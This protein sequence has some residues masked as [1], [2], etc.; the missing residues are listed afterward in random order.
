MKK[1]YK[2]GVLI[3]GLILISGSFLIFKSNKQEIK[4]GQV[5]QLQTEDAIPLMTLTDTGKMGIGIT[6]P[7][8]TLSVL[9]DIDFIGNATTSLSMV[10]KSLNAGSC[11]VKSDTNGLL[12]C[13]TDQTAAGGGAGS[14][15]SWETIWGTTL[16]P[17]SS[18]NGIFVTAS[19]TI[20]T[21]RTNA[22]T[23]PTGGTLTL[24]NDII[25]DAMVSNTLTCSDTVCSDCLNATEIEDIYLF[26]TG[27]SSSGNYFL[28]GEF[29]VNNASSTITNL[30]AKDT[31][32][33]AGLVDCDTAATSKLLWDTTNKVFSC[34]TDQTGAAGN[35]P[36]ITMDALDTGEQHDVTASTALTEITA[37]SQTLAAGTYTFK[38]SVIYRSNQLTNGIRLAVNYSGTNGAFVWWW[39][40]AD[41]SAIASTAVPDQDDVDAAGNVM[42]VFQS[43]AESILT[44]GVTLSVDT[45]DADMLVIIEGVFVATGAGDLELWHG[46]ELATAA[47]TTSV[48]I[49]TSVEIYKTK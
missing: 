17:T 21:F 47:Y 19:S 35:D 30:V 5:Y 9:G 1:L 29:V 44:R 13:G 2:I 40:W 33:G 25:T 39:R 14:P 34:G 42:G 11:D 49:G 8:S 48:M 37:L 23:I 7:T 6:N 12:Y 41:L 22:F 27:D 18:P 43:R 20:L 32:Q 26:N 38:Y 16:T 10:V 28:T 36:R 24:P 31:F 46:S 15:G 3:A 45:I 4:M